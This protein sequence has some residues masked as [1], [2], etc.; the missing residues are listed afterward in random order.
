MSGLETKAMI[1]KLSTSMWTATKK[2]A[3]VSTAV[4]EQYEADA[5]MAQVLKTLVSRPAL[6]EVRATIDAAKALHNDL[7]LPW[8]D[9]G[10]RLLPVKVHARYT[11]TMGDAISKVDE[12]TV[13]FARGYETLIEKARVSLGRMFE[14]T[15][16]P[17][18]EVIAG[19]FGCSYDI[20]PVPAGSHFIANIGD[21][22]AARIKADIER[23]M[24]IKMDAAVLRL[25]E[26]VEESVK[27]LIDRLG[28]DEEGA[29]KR[30]HKSTLEALQALAAAV[31]D[32]NLTEDKRLD[33]IAARLAKTLGGVT[34]D[35]LRYHSNKPAVV[36]ATTQ[37][38]EETLKELEEVAGIY[39]EAPAKQAAE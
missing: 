19:K 26:R 39:F 9:N 4:A 35:D 14:S 28:Y 25:C 29:P 27:H 34:I 22:E 15:D 5:D 33:E 12:A 17:P 38:R 13:K 18:V 31:P 16:Y 3:A 6:K 23:R 24:Q 36:A 32:L 37:R 21:E 1:V 8:A 30:L 11:E 20:N 10:E 7:T 2:D